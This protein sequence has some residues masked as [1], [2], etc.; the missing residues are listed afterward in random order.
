MSEPWED[1]DAAYQAIGRDLFGRDDL[2]EA[3][4]QRDPDEAAFFSLVF[5][6]A[7]IDNGGFSQVFT[8]STGDLVGAAV[9]AADRFALPEHARV[10]R[11]A[12]AQLFPAG[13]PPDLASRLE[14][15]EVLG[16]SADD[17]IQT[18]DERWYAL[19]DVLEERL[20]AY[21]TARHQP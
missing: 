20:H 18:L 15:W 3:L 19:A 2:R 1:I 16:D 14:Q 10:L 7:E 12:S 4:T 5:V 11:E 8:N 13:V 6:G 21:V 9:A 17:V